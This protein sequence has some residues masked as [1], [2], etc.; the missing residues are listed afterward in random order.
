MAGVT[1]SKE[2]AGICQVDSGKG[3]SRQ[4]SSCT[5]LGNERGLHALG[6]CQALKVGR[7]GRSHVLRSSVY[8]GK[9]FIPGKP[10]EGFRLR[11]NITRFVVK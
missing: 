6:W 4:R 10:L 1:K 2:Q 5:R 7:V 9:G 11:D 3:R 8:R